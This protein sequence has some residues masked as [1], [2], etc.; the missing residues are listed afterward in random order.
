LRGLTEPGVSAIFVKRLG[1]RLFARADCQQLVDQRQ[2]C[3]VR[4]VVVLRDRANRVAADKIGTRGLD[5]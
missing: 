2:D 4:L 1:G 5:R 3:R